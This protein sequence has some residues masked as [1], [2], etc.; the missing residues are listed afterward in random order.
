MEGR[1]ITVRF[2]PWLKK[3]FGSKK[4]KKKLNLFTVRYAKI[5]AEIREDEDKLVYVSFT[6]SHSG[7]P[8]TPSPI[9]KRFW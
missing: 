4:D 1:N 2:R 8:R 6:S 5:S 9:A 3:L 7:A